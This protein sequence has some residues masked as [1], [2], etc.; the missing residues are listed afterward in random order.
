[1]TLYGSD[2]IDSAWRNQ[3]I[4]PSLWD[5]H[6][7]PYTVEGNR[8]VAVSW[9]RYQ[10][11][12]DDP[13]KIFHNAFLLEF[14]GDAPLSTI[15]GCSNSP[16]NSRA[17]RSVRDSDDLQTSEHLV[18]RCIVVG[19]GLGAGDEVVQLVIPDAD[20]ASAPGSDGRLDRFDVDRLV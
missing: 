3:A 15:S 10:P 8:A 19:Q 13:E 6:Y 11:L 16:Y 18:H 20:L 5:A 12:Q 9:T 14:D 17:L 1:M 4:E 7:E 2:A